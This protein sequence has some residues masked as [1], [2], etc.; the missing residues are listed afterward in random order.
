[1]ALSNGDASLR[2]DV[3]GS[4]QVAERDL[5]AVVNRRLAHPPRA[6]ANAAEGALAEAGSTC[7][8]MAKPPP[9]TLPEASAQRQPQKPVGFA[10][11]R[12]AKRETFPA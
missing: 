6:A 2:G 12:S 3:R 11:G 8:G 7:A 4:D 10:D 9:R 1:M 5:V